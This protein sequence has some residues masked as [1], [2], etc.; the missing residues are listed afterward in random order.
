MRETVS[1]IFSW[2]FF[3]DGLE[4]IAKWTVP[5]VIAVIFIALGH[6]FIGR[7]FW[8]LPEP[9]WLHYSIIALSFLIYSWLGATIGLALFRWREGCWKEFGATVDR[10]H[11]KYGQ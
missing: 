5:W 7:F 6:F 10:I 8:M 2:E 3:W 1:Y 9:Q 11:N 4:W